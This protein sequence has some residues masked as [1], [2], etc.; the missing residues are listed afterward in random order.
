MVDYITH[1]DTLK[2]PQLHSCVFSTVQQHRH[3]PVMQDPCP[4]HTILLLLILLLLLLLWQRLLLLLLWRLP[5]LLLW[6]LLLL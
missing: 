5:L 3:H 1:N 2:R 6:Q 4:F